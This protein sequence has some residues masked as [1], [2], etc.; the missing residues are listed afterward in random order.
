MDYA[1]RA[2]MEEEKVVRSLSNIQKSASQKGLHSLD[3]S[4]SLGADDR[5]LLDMSSS[6]R[7]LP[8]LFEMGEEC[9]TNE[10]PVAYGHVPLPIP[11]PSPSRRPD[12]ISAGSSLV[13]SMNEFS[14]SDVPPVPLAPAQVK[15]QLFADIPVH[16]LPAE[17]FK[18]VII[19]GGGQNLVVDEDTADACRLLSRACALRKVYM[20]VGPARPVEG[21]IAGS[22]GTTLPTDDTSLENFDPTPS[23]NAM[24]DSKKHAVVNGVDFRRRPE[25]VYDPFST[26]LA[27]DTD[28][29]YQAVDGVYYAHLP[30]EGAIAKDDARLL[31][32]LYQ[33]YVDLREIMTI[34]SHGP[35]KSLAYQRLQLLEARFGLHILLNGDKETA[36]QKCVPHRDFY[37]VR[38]V[39]T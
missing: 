16:S 5:D 2:A 9:C 34:V 7:S 4:S 36:A 21:A 31:P 17:D 33:F 15:E 19:T 38:K 13:E 26:D 29:S 14:L 12:T 3:L 32:S 6:R 27:Q 23:E 39:S 20:G 1:E 30:E 18:R 10:S 8:D 22:A 35:V 28:H 25:P 37:N 11:I 24:I